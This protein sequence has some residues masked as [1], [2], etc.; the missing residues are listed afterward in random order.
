MRGQRRCSSALPGWRALV[1]KNPPPKHTHPAHNLRTPQ[2]HIVDSD[3][4]AEAI[5]SDFV[6]LTNISFAFTA[7]RW[8]AGC[9]A[10]LCSGAMGLCAAEGG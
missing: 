4:G 10:W 2:V 7:P 1:N 5:N 3:N 8:V 9:V 6:T